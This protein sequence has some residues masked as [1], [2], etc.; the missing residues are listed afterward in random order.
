M[1]EITR[2]SASHGKSLEDVL[3]SIASKGG[4]AFIQQNTLDPPTCTLFDGSLT[5]RLI[6]TFPCIAIFGE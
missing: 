3:G 4:M 2:C 6:L 5:C 1:D